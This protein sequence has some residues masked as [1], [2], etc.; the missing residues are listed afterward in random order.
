MSLETTGSGINIKTAEAGFFK[1]LNKSVSISAIV[2][3]LLFLVWVIISRDSA[4][5]VL[6]GIQGAFNSNFGAWYL[7]VSVFYLVV[8]L[9]LALWPK[10]GKIVLGQHGETPEFSRFS[11]FSMM[12]GAGLGVGMLTYAVGEPI[13]HFQNNPD[14]ILGRAEAMSESNIRPAFKWTLLHY[15]LTAWA[16]YGMVGLSM[17]FFSYNR[18]LPLTMRSGLKPLLG[19]HLSGPLGHI[20][21]ISAIIATITGVGYTIALGIKQ[22]AF[23][24]HNISGAKWIIPEGGGEPVFFA[25]II[26][27]VI[28]LLASISSAISGVGKGIKWLSNINMGLSF[29]LLFFFVVFGAF[30]G[31]LLFAVKHYGLAI[32]DYVADFLRMSLSVWGGESASDGSCI[33]T[34]CEL[35]KWQGSWTIFYWAWWIAF[36]PFVGLFLARVSKGRTIRE[37]VLGAMIAPALM[38]LVWFTL[39]GGSAIYAELYGAAN[40]SIFGSDLSAQLFQ[41]INVILTEG[42]VA[43]TLM[44]GIIVILL[45]TYLVTSADSAI[46]VITTIASGGDSA[47]RYTKHIVFWGVLLAAVVAI[48]LGV[49]GLD[50]LQAA[51]II[52]ALP[53]SC[54]VALMGFSLIKA[55]IQQK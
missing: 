24:L 49:G 43:A 44:S 55:V 37:F 38:C 3:I 31:A 28:I 36:A 5:S 12:F 18:G 21:D 34:G 46:L 35:G 11:W 7:Y 41:T 33:D 6:V 20:I 42:S 32:M 4:S 29:F 13:F 47:N 50:A 27:L 9:G 1:G 53:F 40:R 22:F 25:L 15:G 14:V 39:A 45:I 10:S 54:V 16:I 2:I 30:S 51:M 26:C 17:A 8:C 52:G 23:G 19:R 48:L